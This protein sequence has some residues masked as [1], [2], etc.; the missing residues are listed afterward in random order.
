MGTKHLKQTVVGICAAI[1]VVAGLAATTVYAQTQSDNGADDGA[2]QVAYAGDTQTA[3]AGDI[4][5]LADGTTIYDQVEINPSN[6]ISAVGAVNGGGRLFATGLSQYADPDSGMLT[7]YLPG[8]EDMKSSKSYFSVLTGAISSSSSGSGVVQIP[9]FSGVSLTVIG[10]YNI[11]TGEYIDVSGVSG[12]VEVTVD[13]HEQNVFYCDYIASSYDFGTSTDSNLADTVSTN[14]FVSMHLFDYGE[15]FNLYST[16]LD[17]FLNADKNNEWSEYWHDSGKLHDTPNASN[18]VHDAL[19]D[20]DFNSRGTILNNSILFRYAGANSLLYVVEPDAQNGGMYDTFQDVEEVWDI[21]SPDYADNSLLNM[22]FNPDSDALGVTDVGDADYLF[23]YD[24]ESGVY[25]YSSTT[26]AVAYNQT[27][28]RFYVYTSPESY[29]SNNG[30]GDGASLTRNLFSP[31]TA[32]TSRL[33]ENK[34]TNNWWFGMDM[35]VDFTLPDA[36][37]ASG[38]GNVGTDD[39]DMF[40]TVSATDD[41]I[42]FVDDTLVLSMGGSHVDTSPISN[43]PANNNIN[44][45]HT[46]TGTINFATG[47]YEYYIEDNKDESYVS[48]TIDLDAGSH[49]LRVYLLQRNGVASDFGASFNIHDD[50]E[51]FNGTVVWDDADNQD[52]VRPESVTVNLMNGNTVERTQ[53]VSADDGWNFD[54]YADPSA[55]DYSIS[56]VPVDGYDTVV[57]GSIEDG[58]TIT[59]THEPEQT[60]VTGTITWDDASNQDGKRPNFVTVQLFG[61][62]AG[63]STLSM[64]SVDVHAPDDD[65]DV[66]TWTIT[67][68]D[69]NT[70]GYE[71]N[72][73]VIYDGV[74][75]GV[76][77]QEN[78]GFDVVY[79]YTPETTTVS[80]S[81]TWVDDNDADK[82][83]PE[84][85]TIELWANNVVIDEATVGIEDD[86]SWEFSDLPVYEA[87]NEITYHITEDSVDNYNTEYD[88]FNMTNTLQEGETSVTVFKDWEDAN[89]QDGIRP[90]NITVELLANGDSTGKT[91]TLSEDNN[92]EGTFEG[93]AIYEGGV[94][95]TYSVVE[96]EVSGYD[97]EIAGNATQGFSIINT[98]EP[99]KVEVSGTKTWDDA[100]NQDGIRPDTVYVHLLAD[101]ETIDSVDVSESAEETWEFAFS[102]LDKYRDGGVAIEYTVEEAY[103]AEGY[104]STVAGYMTDGFTIENAHTPETTTVSGTKVW[105][106]SQDQDGIRP[107]EITVNLFADD[108]EIDSVT[109]STADEWAYSFTDL[110]KYRDGGTEI[111]YTVAEDAVENYRTVIDGDAANGFTITNY[112]TPETITVSGTVA[113]DDADDQD[114]MRPDE[115]TV[116]LLADGTEVDSWD[117]NDINEDGEPWPYD[118]YDLPKYRD[119]GVAIEYTVTVDDI[120]EYTTEIDGTAEDGFVIT[121]TH[122]PEKF[123][124]DGTFK[125]VLT[126]DDEANNDGIRPAEV[127]ITLTKNNTAVEGATLTLTADQTDADGNWIGTFTGL[128]KYE[129][130]EEISYSV[131]EDYLSGYTYN[132]EVLTAND[133]T[134]YV[135]L[136]NVHVSVKEDIEVTKV[137]NDADNQD[138]IRPESIEVRLLTDGTLYKSV[139][140]SADTEGVEVGEGGNVWKY[141]MKDIPVDKNGEAIDYTMIEADVANYNPVVETVRGEETTDNGV[142][143]TPYSFT[144]YNTHTPAQIDITG[145]KVWDDADDQDGK[146]P[147]YVTLNLFADDEPVASMDVSADDDTDGD[148]AWDW[149]FTGFD[150]Y[151]DGGVEIEYTVTEDAVEEYDTTIEGN[152]ENGFEITN[153]YEPE[154]TTI[155]GSKTWVD[156]DNADNTR[157]SEI[158]VRLHANGNEKV[159]EQTVNEADGWAWEFTDVPV[160]SGGQEIAYT[161]TEDAVDDYD[162]TYD[163]FNVTNTLDEGQTSVTVVKDWEDADNQD[164]IRPNEVTVTLL[165]NGTATDRTLTLNTENNWEGTFAGLAMYE[166]GVR[167]AYTVDEIETAGYTCDISGD[168]TQ[169]YVITNTH[170]PEKTSVSGIKVW[171]DADDQ[172]GIRPDEVTVHLLA[173]GEAVQSTHT[174]SADD[175]QFSFDDLDKYAAGVEIAYSVEEA[176]VADGYEAAVDGFTITNSHTPEVI[177]IT[178]TKTW[179]DADNQDGIRPTDLTVYLLANGQAVP[180]KNGEPTSYT[181]DEAHGWTYEFTDL[182]K[183]ANGT[184]I[185]YS[186]TEDVPDGYKEAYSY[187]SYDVANAHTPELLNGDGTLDVIMRWDDEE[188]QDGIRPTQTTI[189]LTRDGVPAEDVTLVLDDSNVDADGNWIGT[190][191]NLDKYANGAEIA[192][193]VEEGVMNGYTYTAQ[194]LFDEDSG[195]YYVEITNTHAAVTSDITVT[196]VWDDADNQD[197]KRSDRVTLSL[198]SNGSEVKSISISATYAGVTV[199]NDG[200]EWSYTFANMPVDQNGEPIVYTLEE[201]TVDEYTNEISTS[202]TAGLEKDGVTYTQ[203]DFT[204]TNTHVPETVT[205]SGTKTWDDADNQDGIRPNSITIELLADGVPALDANNEP[206]EENV[207]PLVDGSWQWAFTD[208][209]KYRDGG[210]EIAYSFEE[211]QVD[212]YETTY[213]GNDVINTH[214][215]ETTSIVGEKIWVDDDNAYNTRPESITVNLYANGLVYKR[216]TVTEA[217]GWAW[218]FTDLPVY[219]D[220]VKI[221]YITT[222]T[223]IDD[224]DTTYSGFNLTNTLDPGETSVTVFKDWE[225][226][227]NQD[228]IRPASVEVALLADGAATGETLTLSDENNWE[229]TFTGVDEY[230]DGKRIEYTV[231]ETVVA[232][233]DAAIDGNAADGF[234]ITNTYE[235]ESLDVTGTKVW[236]DADNQDGI[237]PD[238]VTIRLLA[239]GDEIEHAEVDESCDWLWEFTD[240]PVYRDGGTEIVYTITEDAVAE[241]D[242]AITGTVADG[243]TITNTHTPELLNGD[244]TLTVGKTWDDADNQDG[245]RPAYVT[246]NLL[247]DDEVIQ[248]AELNAEDAWTYTFTDLPK[249]R[250]GGIEIEYAIEEVTVDDYD[251]AIT[252]DAAS[253]FTITNTHTPEVTTI[254]GMKTWVD[255]DNA[256]NS[257]PDSIMIALYANNKVVE[258]VSVTAADDWSW[259]FEDMPVYADGQEIAYHIVENAVDEYDTTYDGYNV[260]NT[261]N[262]GETSVTVVKYWDDANNQDG[263]RPNNITVELWADGIQTESTMVLNDLNNWEGAFTGLDEY[264]GG[265]RIT[266]TVNEVDVSEAG[267]T[268]TLEGNMLEGYVFTNTY[269]P[270][271][272]DISGTKTWDDTDNQDGIRPDEVT[273]H[274]LADGV[275]VDST[276]VSEDANGEWAFAFNDL[277][278]YAA[279]TEIEYTVEEVAV[280]GYKTEVEGDATQGFEITN[281][282]ETETVSVTGTKTW[283]DADDQDGVRPSE[284]TV[285]LLADGDEI[286]SAT[287]S[288]TDGWTYGFDGLPKY[289]DSGMEIKYTIEEDKIEGYTAEIDGFD[290]TNTHIPETV[291]VEGSKTWDDADNQDGKRPE[292]I[293]VRLLADNAEVDSTTVSATDEWA[294]SFDDLPKYRDGGIEIAYTIAEDAVSGYDTTIDGFDITNSYTPELFNGD[295]TFK[296]VLTWDDEANNDGIRP[297]EV[298]IKLTKNNTEVE[299]S[300]LTLTADNVDENGNWIGEFTGLDKY[301]NGEEIA[302]SVKEDYLSG[303]TYRIEVK[304]ADDGTTYVQLTSVHVSVK[305]DIEVTKVWDD[306]DNQDGLRPD[307]I[308]VRL[309]LNGSLYKTV[310]LTAETEGVTVS[311]DGNV[312]TYTMSSIPVDKNG[313]N[314]EYTLIE[315]DVDNYSPVIETFRGDEITDN[316]VTYQPYSFTVTNSHTPE[317]IEVA[318]TKT[319]DDADD[320][321]G[322]RPPSVTVH[323][324]ADGTEIDDTFVVLDENDEWTFSFDG[325]EK[326]RDGGT[327]IEYT[328]SEDTVDGYTSEINGSVEDGFEIINSYTPET[329]SISGTKTWDDNN[330]QDGKRPDE[331]T[332]RL[333]ANNE[334]VATETVDAADGWSWTFD[335]LPV[336]EDGTKIAYT[337][338]ED[339]VDEYATSID[340]SVED[341]FE[342]TN[343]YTPGQTSVT[344]VKDWEDGNNQDGRRPASVTVTLLADG[345]ETGDELVLNDDNNWE[346]TFTELN[347][348]ESGTRI[349]YSI[350]EA[351]VN[352]YDSDISG[353]ATQG[354]VITNTREPEKMTIV[355]TKRWSDSDDQDGMRPDELT[356]FLLVDM[357]P[358]QSTTTS[359]ADNWEFS[360]TDVDK[361]AAGSRIS[362]N[363]SELVPDGYSCLIMGDAASEFEMFNSHTP[364]KLNGDGTLKVV[365]TWD[366][367]ADND[368]I[369]PS[370]VNVNLTKNNTEVE[371]KSLTLTAANTDADGNWIG[372]FTGLD[373]YES[374][375]EIAYSV[376]EDYLSGYTYR[377]E[378]KTA[379]DGTTYVQLTNVHVSVTEDIEVTKV[380]DDSGNQDGLRPDSITVRLLLN[381]TLYKTVTLTADTEGVSVSNGGNTWTYTMK[382]IPVDKNGENVQYTLIEVDVDNY[383]PVV[384]TYRGDDVTDNGVTYQ[385]YSFTVT[386]SHTPATTEVAVSKTWDDGDDQ[387]G[388]RP[389][390]VE[391]DLLADG[392]T[393]T[394]AD[395]TDE[396]DWSYTFTDLPKYRDEGVEI[397]YSVAEV[398]VT[399]YD[400]AI[401]GNAASGFAITNTHTPETTTI[402]G[403]KIWDDENNRDGKRPDEVKVRLHADGAVVAEQTVSAADEWTWSFED[404]PVYSKGNYVTYLVTE[405]G[406]EDYSAAYG[407]YNVT[408]SY[409]PE[410]TSVTVMKD[411]EDADNQDGVRPASVEVVLVADGTETDKTLT[412]NDEN[413]W[414]GTFTEL[415]VYD[416]GTPIVYTV[417]EVSVADYDSVIDGDASQG[418]VITNTHKTETVSVSGVKAWNDANDQDGLRPDE[419]TVHLLADGETVQSTTATAENDWKFSFADLDKYAAGT[420]IEYTVEEAFVADGY[421]VEVEGNATDGFEITNTHE[422]ETVDVEGIKTWDDADDQ[423]GKRPS[424]ITVNLLADGNKIDSA[425]VGAAD[426]WAFSFTDMPVYRDSGIDIVYAI[427][428]DAVDDYDT[429]IKGTVEDGFTVTNSYTPETVDVEGTKTWDDA[430]DQDGKRPAEITV[431]L[432][433]DGTE[434]DSATVNASDNWEYSFDD[435][436]VYRDGGIEI[437]YA[438]TEDEVV[439]YDTVIDGYDITNSYTPETTS[440]TGTKTWDDADNNDGKRPDDITIRLHADGEVVQSKTVSASDNW[441]YSFDDLPVYRDGGVEITYMITEDAI[442]DY[443]TTYDG[444]DITNSYTPSQTSVTVMKDWED[445]DNQDGIRPASV[446]VVLVV[447]GTE[448]D[449][450]L[451]LN[452]ENNWEGTFVG[453]DEYASGNRIAYS[454]AEVSVESYESTIAGDATGGFVI[455]NEYEPETIDIAGVK[456]WDDADN[457]DGIRP[458]DITIRL[459]ADGDEVDSVAPTETGLWKWSFTDLPRYRDGGIEIDYTVAED[460]V[461]SY[462]STI[463]GF[464]ITNSYTPELFNEDGKL[465]VSLTW[466]DDN[467]HDGLRPA[468][469]EVTLLANGVE[470]GQ[471]LTLSDADGWMG[472]FADLPKYEYGFEIKYTVSVDPIDEYT[473][474]IDSRVEGGYTSIEITESH[475]VEV[476]DISDGLVGG[477]ESSYTYTGSAIVP[478]ITVTL[479]GSS[480][481]LVEGEDYAV[482]IENNINVGT[483]TV[484]I[485]GLEPYYEGTIEVTFEI[486]AA[487]IEDATVV[488]EP[489]TYTYTGSEITPD[490]VTVTLDG[491]ELV[492]GVDYTIEITDNIDAGTATVTV[493]G[494]GNYDGEALGTFEIKAVSIEDATVVVEPDTYTYTGSEITP[495]SVTVTLPDGTELVEG[496]DYTIEITDNTDVGTA[497]VTVTGIGNYEGA[498]SGTFEIVAATHEIEVED[499]D[500]GHHGTVTVDHEASDG[501]QV[502]VTVT[503]EEG[504]TLVTL[505]FFD[506]DTGD[507]ITSL[508]DPVQISDDTWTFTMPS[509]NVVIVPVWEAISPE[510]IPITYD[511]FD[512]DT[513]YGIYDGTNPVTKTIVGNNDGTPMVLDTDYTVTYE[514]NEAVGEAKI[515]IEGIGDYE[516]TLEYTFKIIHYFEDVGAYVDY[517]N[518]WYFDAVYGLVDLDVIT[519]YNMDIFGVGDSMTRAQLVT[520]LWRYCEPDQYRNYDE[521]NAKDT[522]GLPDAQNGMYYTEAV[523]WAFNNGVITG[524]LHDADGYYTLDPDDPV[525]FEQLAAILARYCLGSFDAA[526]NYPT[527]SLDNGSFTDKDAVEGF[528]RGPMAWAID[529]GI[530]TGNCNDDGTWTLSPLENVARERAVTVLYRSIEDGLLIAERS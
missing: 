471:T 118:F 475:T 147:N 262:T 336:Y 513:S 268:G 66:W 362:Y 365:L 235:P 7:I 176:Y 52:G 483:A 234:V 407:N 284:I 76:Y 241:Y 293:T 248:Q 469:V 465:P 21:T 41:A 486:T 138:G 490:S 482:E 139:T 114:G 446:E 416:S 222:E 215:P 429:T 286:D 408:N 45:F 70:A 160:Y 462:D 261:L 14:D 445:A 58:Y 382:D 218:E 479:P 300:G 474:E 18:Q 174:T 93:L 314:V 35:S 304:T 275:A 357:E 396:N 322:K 528:A 334:V 371:G 90:E 210:V 95:I 349:E 20:D 372:E 319:W 317:T 467:D 421:D 324:F 412:L 473:C 173:D 328:I 520:I 22:L 273:V 278:K 403:S 123:N 447:D 301:E 381:D 256:Y 468:S 493:T 208:L 143:Y 383:A 400:S 307:F 227:D 27:D 40:F 39:E 150:K 185:E 432:L 282:H 505:R 510:K 132:I 240:L 67:G 224:Y 157:P 99:E 517:V 230:L 65:S 25:S 404:M 276:A 190:F 134:L 184:E 12:G 194:L 367:G 207:T 431:R 289:R 56:Q 424:E 97:T 236:S 200:N 116:H 512:V 388:I 449:K 64:Q 487:S 290:I 295:G 131:K 48:G 180:D 326:Y 318:G 444:F 279:G 384:D 16:S 87:G 387:D 107:S 2:A 152:A 153:T 325:L 31:F 458:A 269:E 331:I 47:E 55:G 142:T 136:T 466:D 310:T 439:D 162:A 355:G 108:D 414:E 253:G 239:D 121:Y 30:G 61:Q 216:Q 420:E 193:S 259:T 144:V 332:I 463:D 320:Q 340:G 305:E 395:L 339:A 376:S 94:R 454:V 303:Y 111:V 164:G 456:M 417:K 406:L 175:W 327:K 166:G 451:T 158:T 213:D 398:E 197:G 450:T 437:T 315:V 71:I 43:A 113:W 26:N 267:Y 237:R 312:W 514:N 125:V 283:D 251:S 29:Y 294:Y 501:S 264:S 145:T 356:V 337:I 220:G 205:A 106:D 257:R 443:S 33:N 202:T 321:D 217:D 98:H 392:Q 291:E 280:D 470:T 105:D 80:G 232:D 498:A 135:Q 60:E 306:S 238:S 192:Y 249:Y 288:E 140:L 36:T 146:R 50:F 172:D 476:I 389:A 345:V 455:T 195:R 391:V 3:S 231:E 377:I 163:G 167:I 233:Y 69:K 442:D 347:E 435:L 246:V 485:T 101:S 10:W 250:D 523:N 86:W 15:M 19:D 436:P 519:G 247:A 128:D 245:I 226:A 411:W 168:A 494:T 399:G 199:S 53:T 258:A 527:A 477:I 342:I 81:K 335:D 88:G 100:D 478:D 351:T 373:K 84:N 491:V 127:N 244:G 499:G 296:V 397:E 502:A 110:P 49:T 96:L 409:T 73:A 405:D 358:V 524:N 359:A 228:G 57:A 426:G 72:Y 433:A 242:T 89:N 85:I 223:A 119:G 333:H 126:W 271:T 394:G 500:T 165:A 103:V 518:E 4:Q 302:Y 361:Y 353:D 508:C 11:D 151:R 460:E 360:F 415:N 17:R 159:Y 6:K 425:T 28:E 457:Q 497:T 330:N 370:E 124:G 51:H 23:S 38:S 171:N 187:Y 37:A 265:N 252:G 83:R 448:T 386:N 413:D 211:L 530:V 418:F 461:E 274:L 204:V 299:G 109:V 434:I 115:V 503:A 229:G 509:E 32:G 117:V 177:D 179:D 68:L 155:T 308:T 525:T 364:E 496:V 196:K 112:Y 298:N 504:F 428:E 464:A 170:E 266:Y 44:S 350:A 378:V 9:T 243:F 452:D 63:G 374:G 102:D 480:T 419:V 368:G 329:T 8:E 427:T 5:T 59:N 255:N 78:S 313:E 343:S 402:T 401:E 272:I 285:N 137:W 221:T 338:T 169:G 489:D 120:D 82:L 281:T 323:L 363:V 346:G 287:V 380:W 13:M 263:V 203:Y 129:A 156:N 79:S 430:D 379:D 24:E 495:D 375:E 154:T 423:D 54:F 511:M 92:G 522:T 352:Y 526:A 254:S 529:N 186:V 178:G 219:S 133:D 354:F 515:I 385:P 366:D 472:T 198:Y 316:G 183:C 181:T 344:V 212:G 46:G 481:P 410:Q 42:V 122:T 309:L 459:L 270:E 441:E 260:T 507:E 189:T 188:D 369:R 225:D 393:V 484:T 492:E 75:P 74:D 141:T 453:L 201:V 130:G 277:D 341:G 148:G 440:I 104:E 348:Y 34:N 516:G 91:L 488:V 77:G 161:L 292:N 62:D 422:P 149:A 214:V 182:D 209:P 206:V 521:P 506:A 1:C 438:I 297:D 311:D 390:F 191:E